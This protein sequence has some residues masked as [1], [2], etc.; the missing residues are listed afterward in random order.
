M[1][2]LLISDDMNFAEELAKK[3]VFLRSLDDIVISNYDNAFEQLKSIAASVVLVHENASNNTVEL[4]KRLR[5]NSD[6]CIILLANSCNSELILSAADIGVDDFMLS[7]AADFELVLRIVNNIRHNSVKLA[8][9]RNTSLLEN[10]KVINNGLYSNE[11]C[12]QVI[13]ISDAEKNGV[14]MVVAPSQDAKAYFEAEVLA[15]AIKASIRV[16]DILMAGRGVNFY[17]FLPRTDFNGAVKV[18]QKI[19]EH[20]DFEICAGISDICNKSFEEFEADGLKALSD[21]GLAGEEVGFAA[22]KENTLEEWLPDVKV[23]NYKFFR[24]VFNQKMDKV[25]ASVFYRL[26]KAYEE[27]LFETEIIQFTNEEQCVFRL[28]NKKGES[29]L[30]IIYPGFSKIIIYIDHEGLDSPENYEIQLALNKIT[31]REL[32]KIVEDFIKEYKE[33]KC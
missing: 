27:K 4:I 17:L 23:P 32:I 8:A 29:S 12:K 28:K 13:E 7:S 10:M 21:A 33:T 15:K 31:Q 25:I 9:K 11:Y 5:E 19:K 30:K 20:V 2:I 22:E 16:S 3:L 18:F 6:L 14:F 1:K 24:K 26:Q